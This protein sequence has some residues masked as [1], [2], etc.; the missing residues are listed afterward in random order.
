MPR[1]PAAKKA[2]TAPVGKAKPTAKKKAGTPAAKRK[3]KAA[4]KKKAKTDDEED[5]EDEEDYDYDAE[6]YDYD[7][8]EDEEEEDEEE[9]E[10][11]EDE[12]E[13]EDEGEKD[14]E[15]ETTEKKTPKKGGLAKMQEENATRF[16]AIDLRIAD[17]IKQF[18]PLIQLHEAYTNAQKS[19]GWCCKNDF[20]AL[21]AKVEQPAKEPLA[22]TT[23]SQSVARLEKQMAVLKE[24]LAAQEQRPVAHSAMEQ[25][26]DGAAGAP[27]PTSVPP[28]V[29]SPA[30]AAV[31]N[32]ELIRKM[33]L[34]AKSSETRHEQLEARVQLIEMQFAGSNNCLACGMYSP[35]ATA[36]GDRSLDQK[37]GSRRNR[38]GA[39]VAQ[40]LSR[41]WEHDKFDPARPSL[42]KGGGFSTT[43]SSFFGD[44]SRN[45]MSASQS[46]PSM[47]S[48]PASRARK[49]AGYTAAY[50]DTFRTDGE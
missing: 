3:A 28:G 20:K 33:Q 1:Q 40:F 17:F 22:L 34:F 16:D 36:I 6:D 23:L 21:K 9:D 38:V 35:P 48:M 4:P 30:A 26:S 42:K 14:E 29:S 27:K 46:S 5:E 31:D 2:A 15:T 10:E 11:A 25:S 32:G 43:A 19:G 44:S 47:S 37:A 24:Q 18:S 50:N 49:R 41:E 7:A 13:D 39:P 12:E 8:E 45:Q